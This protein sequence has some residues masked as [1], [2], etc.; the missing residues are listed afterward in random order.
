MQQ[1]VQLVG[2]QILLNAFLVTLDIILT[3]WVTHV[4]MK[5]HVETDFE[6][7][8]KTVMMEI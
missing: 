6:T 8:K 3:I 2:E 7:H 1:S 5:L 4:Q